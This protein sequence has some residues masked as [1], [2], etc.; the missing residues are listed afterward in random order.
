MQKGVAVLNF[1][2]GRSQE[3][4]L[5]FGDEID[6]SLGRIGFPPRSSGNL[7]QT[8]GVIN[9]GM[10]VIDNHLKIFNGNP[11]FQN[12]GRHKI[13]EPAFFEIGNDPRAIRFL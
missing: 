1:F 5:F 4:L 7:N 2:N 11:S 6:F 10:G 13:K 8:G 3:W 12:G 9:F